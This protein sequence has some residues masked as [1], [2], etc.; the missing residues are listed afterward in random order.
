LYT[1]IQKKEILVDQQ[2]G[3]YCWQNEYVPSISPA[4][5]VQQGLDSTPSRSL[6]VSLM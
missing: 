5:G 4:E 6:R 3:D 2:K 1:E